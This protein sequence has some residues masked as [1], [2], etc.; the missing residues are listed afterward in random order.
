M[1]CASTPTKRPSRCVSRGASNTHTDVRGETESNDWFRIGGWNG[2]GLR[3]GQRRMTKRKIL[4][5]LCVRAIVKLAIVRLSRIWCEWTIPVCRPRPGP[6]ITY[7]FNFYL[8]MLISLWLSSGSDHCRSG[9]THTHE[10]HMSLFIIHP[11]VVAWTRPLFG[12]H[13]LVW[14]GRVRQP[15]SQ[16]SSCGWCPLVQLLCGKLQNYY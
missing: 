2:L 14:H 9:S 1:V 5:W 13:S 12:G 6:A 11:L 7:L 3:C 4:G 10:P 8:F 16:P 15:A